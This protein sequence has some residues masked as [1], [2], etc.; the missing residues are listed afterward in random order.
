M[1]DR[2]DVEEALRTLARQRRRVDELTITQTD[3]ADRLAGHLRAH[4]GPDEVETAGLALVLGAASVTA[5]ATDVSPAIAMNVLA[6][7]GQRLVADSRA[8]DAAT[9]TDDGGAS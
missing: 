3:I 7:A 9:P 5:V 4:F 2:Y 8:A 6:F 1:A